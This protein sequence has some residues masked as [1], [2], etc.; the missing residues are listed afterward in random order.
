M[1]DR[2]LQL[3]QKYR[4]KDDM[5]SKLYEEHV[6]YERELEKFNNK[7]FLSADEEMERKTLQKKKLRGRDHIELILSKYRKIEQMS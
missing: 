7:P 2:D 1:E 4:E 5:L 6:D 3:I